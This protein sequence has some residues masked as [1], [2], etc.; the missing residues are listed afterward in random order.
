MPEQ[1]AGHAH[2]ST[3]YPSHR[4]TCTT[5]SRRTPALVYGIQTWEWPIVLASSADRKVSLHTV[6]TNHIAVCVLPLT[7]LPTPLAKTHHKL[8]SDGVVQSD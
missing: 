1:F 8:C 4:Q 2:G 5:C 6:V 7:L 3:R